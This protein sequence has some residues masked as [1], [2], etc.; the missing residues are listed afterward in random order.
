MHR[1]QLLLAPHFLVCLQKMHAKG[2][3]KCFMGRKK[4]NQKDL[5]FH[6]SDILLSVY[7]VMWLTTID[8]G[9]IVMTSKHQI[10]A[11]LGTEILRIIRRLRSWWCFCQE[12]RTGC[13]E[14]GRFPTLSLLSR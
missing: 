12:I 2:E 9:P 6:I 4:Q 14:E 13:Q 10:P 5:L 8:E 1:P 11:F 3:T 7:Y